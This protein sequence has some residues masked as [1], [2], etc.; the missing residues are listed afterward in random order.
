MLNFGSPHLILFKWN[1]SNIGQRDSCDP[2]L[3]L[4][5]TILHCCH[6]NKW[7]G[8]NV[9]LLKKRKKCFPD[10]EG[11]NRSSIINST[12]K[13][14]WQTH[15]VFVLFFV[16]FSPLYLKWTLAVVVL[17]FFVG[18]TNEQH[19][20]TVILWK[21]EL[22]NKKTAE[23]QRGTTDA[24]Q[25]AGASVRWLENYWMLQQGTL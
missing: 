20:G 25:I 18:S 21:K 2:W 23:L 3:Q 5:L 9:L 16:F 24:P 15:C 12:W 10:A 11:W 13:R 6:G 7:D 1:K 8:G 4:T 14:Q 17:H 19:S 22:K